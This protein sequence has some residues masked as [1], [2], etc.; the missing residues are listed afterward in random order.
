[1]NIKLVN[2]KSGSFRGGS[3]SN[4]SLIIS[5]D[6]IVITLIIQRYILN[7]YHMYILCAVMD[8]T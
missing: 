1:M 3:N 2:T 5:E 6:E 8:I 7:W 4:F